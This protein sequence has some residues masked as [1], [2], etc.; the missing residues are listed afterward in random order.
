[1]PKELTHWIIAERA[2]KE[3][4]SDSRLYGVIAQNKK[5]YLAG[6]VLPDTLLHLFCGQDAKLALSAAGRFHNTDGN[7]YDPLIRA[8]SK[9]GQLLSDPMLS[10]LLG[11]IS[12][13]QADMVF[14]PYIFALT[15]TDDIG[16]HYQLETNIDMYLTS[17]CL[18]P[19]V[20]RL[21]DLVTA[22]TEQTIVSTAEILFST[23]SEL[24]I[25]A[26]SKAL[27]LHCRFQSMYSKTFWKL[28]VNLLGAFLGNP[29]NQHRHLFYPIEL[30]GKQDFNHMAEAVE[31]EHPVTGE[32]RKSKIDDLVEDAVKRTVE[33]FRQIEVEKTLVAALV[34][35]PGCNLLTGMYAVNSS[36]MFKIK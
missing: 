12:H 33:M 21:Y 34:D 13:M 27:K 14:H 31:W 8:E 28:V 15:G 20:N 16:R 32:A 4:S 26:I 22:E 30:F 7:S 18:Q 35:P 3:L 24:P 11:V 9:Y 2:C 29:Y 5:E 1:M 17:K 25:A 23:A 10:C 19:P 6:A 36:K